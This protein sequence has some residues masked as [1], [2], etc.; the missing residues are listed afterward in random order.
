MAKKRKP[1]PA[2]IDAPLVETV[3]LTELRERG[4]SASEI[5]TA[6]REAI[7]GM[8]AAG[9]RINE[10][11][12]RVK[13]DWEVAPVTVRRDLREVGQDVQRQLANEGVLEAERGEVLDRLRQRAQQTD[14][15]RTAQRADETLYRILTGSLSNFRLNQLGLQVD[16]HKA[17]LAELEEQERAARTKLAQA[18]AELATAQKDRVAAPL[19]V[20]LRDL[21]GELDDDDL[22]AASPTVTE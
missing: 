7:R 13:R 4:A 12:S 20:I 22:A 1:K 5:K 11:Y 8:V 3:S 9:K 16:A 21:V 6:R 2:S 14:D 17:R 19:V 15:L 18:K 10:I